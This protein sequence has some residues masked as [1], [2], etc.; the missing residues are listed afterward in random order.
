MAK[1]I[2][3]LL[4]L[5]LTLFIVPG[6]SQSTSGN[7]SQDGDV[8]A[9]QFSPGVTSATINF[10]QDGVITFQ[11]ETVL[12]GFELDV[13]ANE[14]GSISNLDAAEFPAGTVCIAYSTGFCVRYDVTG[15]VVGS[16][17]GVPIRGVN[18][19]GLITL[20]LNYD[21]DQ[22]IHIPAFGHAPESSTPTFSENILT[23]YVDPSANACTNC[24]PAMGGRTPGISSFAALDIPFSQTANTVCPSL[25][26]VSQSST[27]GNNPIVEVSFK[28]VASGGNC[29]NGPFLRDKTATL[30]VASGPLTNLVFANLVNNGDSNKFHFDNKNGVNVQDINTNG[31]APGLYYVTVISNDFSPVTTMFTI[32]P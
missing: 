1:R 25:T 20:T 9:C 29:N 28:L 32:N 14:V 5:S 7:C 27:S 31:L 18:Y 23:S 19:K 3:T 15:N 2:L 16:P 30:T 8:A 17:N 10:V 21:S 12:V 24:D 6:W 13:T 22:V 26:A 11:F 4:L